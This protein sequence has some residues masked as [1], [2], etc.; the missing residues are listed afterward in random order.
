MANRQKVGVT[1]PA[2]LLAEMEAISVELEIGILSQGDYD[3]KKANRYLF[4]VSKRY[5]YSSLFEGLIATF[6]RLK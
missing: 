6:L 1:D 5:I 2:H 3:K 4:L